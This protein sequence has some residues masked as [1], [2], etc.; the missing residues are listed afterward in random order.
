LCKKGEVWTWGMGMGVLHSQSLM[1]LL[2][3]RLLR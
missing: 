3:L 1:W 2:R